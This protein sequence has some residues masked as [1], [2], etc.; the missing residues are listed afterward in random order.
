[1]RLNDELLQRFITTFYGSGNYEGQYWFVGM[2]EGGGNSLDQVAKRINTW[3]ELGETELVDIYK[4]HIKINYPEYFTNP[5]KLQRTWMQMARIILVSKGLSTSV[6][7]IKDYQRDIIGRSKS[8]TCLL[9]LLPLPSPNTAT[10]H[11][12]EWSSL[13]YLKNRKIYKNLCSPLRCEHLHSQINIYQPKAVV[14]MGSSYSKY[15]QSIMGHD[16]VV[17][18]KGGFGAAQ[19]GKT[20]FVIAKHPAAR[21]IENNYFENIGW[22]IKSSQ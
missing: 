17:Q 16:V 13:P 15:W 11:Y 14:F 10:W 19:L 20:L 5:V 6:S 22:F 1:M 12:D 8:E 4:F 7:D 9:E 3:H 18:D 21:G 2:E